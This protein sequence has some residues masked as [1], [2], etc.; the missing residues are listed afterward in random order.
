[1]TTNISVGIINLL[2]LHQLL[3]GVIIQS[4]P[5]SL[6]MK[7]VEEARLQSHTLAQQLGCLSDR[8]E[9]LVDCLRF[10]SIRPSIFSP[11]LG[12]KQRVS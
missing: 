12:R 8:E 3:Q 10:Y 6:P 4:S 11:A 5:F 9:L 2:E 1:M 7:S